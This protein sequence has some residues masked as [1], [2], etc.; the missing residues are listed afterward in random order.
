VSAKRWFLVLLCTSGC[1][2]TKAK[3]PPAA[4]VGPD[5]VLEIV[6]DSTL[7]QD[8]IL[9]VIEEELEAFRVEGSKPS[10]DDAAWVL[11]RHLHGLGYPRAHVG[12]EYERS[13]EGDVNARL[14]VEQGPRT[15]LDRITFVGVEGVDPAT[16]LRSFGERLSSLGRRRWFVER[17]VRARL[18]DIERFYRTQ[19]YLKV[20]VDD[21][22][23]DF[24]ENGERVNLT[25]NVREGPRFF[26]REVHFAGVDEGLLAIMQGIVAGTIGQ[27]FSPRTPS[28]LRSRLE[29]EYSRRGYPD[30]VLT[31][32]VIR[33][34]STGDTVILFSAE[35][36]DR[37]EIARVVIRGNEKTREGF[38]RARL[39]VAKGDLYD[40]RR[41]QESFQDL[42]RSR[43]FRRIDLSLEGRGPLRTLVV[44]VEE[45]PYVEAW[46]E[47]GW[48]SYELARLSGGIRGRNVFGGGRALSLEGT[49]AVRAQKLILSLTNP[50]FLGSPYQMTYSLFGNRRTEPFV[51]SQVGAGADLSR[52]WTDEWSSALGYQF[53]FSD[54]GGA[55]SSGRVDVSSF[56]F[57]TTRD[58]RND[59]FLPNHGSF[60]RVSFEW[61]APAIGSD[62]DFFR[63]RY[64]QSFFRSL[65]SSTVA[66]LSFRGGFIAPLDDEEIPQQ[67]R[68]INGGENTVR[69]F[70]EGELGPQTKGE[71]TGGEAFSVSSLELRQHMFRGFHGALFVDAGNLPLEAEQAFQFRDLRYALGFGVRYLLPIGPLRLDFA[72]NPHPMDGEEG[73][74]LHFSVGMPF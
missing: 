23:L 43:L 53:R 13:D 42:Y 12:Y 9:E 2:S 69:S 4:P 73:F 46:V 65:T 72:W 27:P 45:L 24:D 66:A 68:F 30:A 15:F 8:D 19:G 59:I 52:E 56:V 26:V 67:E 22:R 18:Q 48:G 57:T 21:P 31:Y 39:R 35:E 44:Q 16:L 36:G 10:V 47:P 64:T 28:S 41:V 38:I 32:D 63:M 20:E 58:T 51:T 37:V 29:G 55:L 54:L 25:V 49:A 60:N 6:G 7:D 17:E 5:R 3:A 11:E 1:H 33:D 14:I 50:F 71:P 40:S 74:V 34:E 61:G 62:L 70:R